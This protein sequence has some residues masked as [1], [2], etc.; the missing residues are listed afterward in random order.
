M[1]AKNHLIGCGFGLITFLMSGG[2]VIA[3]AESVSASLTIRA[4]EP[5]KPISADLVG[6]F[7][8]DLNYAAD[9]GLYAELIQNRS[10]EYSATEQSDWGPLSFWDLVKTGEG[11]GFLA[12]G[13]VRPVHR[14][15][16]HYLLLN[17]K[18]AGDGVGM[19]NPGFD[20]I[21]VLEGKAY[22]ASFWSY[23]TYMNEKWVPIV[24]RMEDPCR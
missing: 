3:S 7:F 8:E 17:V 16:P 15:N 13:E 2:Q 1:K 11:D 20:G 21:P 4:D 9:G 18:T 14:N 6:V 22:R 10:F 24:Q 5:G 19:S 12:V 23:Q